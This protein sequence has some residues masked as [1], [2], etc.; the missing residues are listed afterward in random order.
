MGGGGAYLPLDPSAPPER[1]RGLIEDSGA[2]VVIAE[3]AEPGMLAPGVRVV[4]VN[5]DPGEGGR[6]APLGG[7]RPNQLAYVLYTSGST[8]RPKAVAATHGGLAQLAAAQAA[9][10][11]VTADTRT[12][13]YAATSSMRR[14]RKCA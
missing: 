1:L 6:R 12:L 4:G 7:A 9:A 13:Q 2:T 3:A 8:G 10:F 5:E 11:G 14:C